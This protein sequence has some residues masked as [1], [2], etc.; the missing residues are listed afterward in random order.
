[1]TPAVAAAVSVAEEHGI[2][3]LDPVVLNDSFNLRVHLRPAP[4]V[5]RV[6]T[7]TALGRARPADALRR[8][9]DVV[10]YLHGQGVPVVP[11]SD[12]LPAGPHL[13]DGV[14][15]SFWKHVE[16]DPGHRM[17]PETAGRA[18]AGLHEALRGFPGELPYLGPVLDEP[19]RLLDL[20][21]LREVARDRNVDV[22]IGVV[23]TTPQA[24]YNYSVD[25]PADGSAPIYYAKWHFAPGAPFRHGD[26]LLFAGDHVGLAN[27]M[28]LNFPAPIRDYARA[29]ARLMAVP[30]ADE[31]GNGRQHSRMGLLRGVE[32]GLS[33]AW[34]AQWGTPMISDP[35]GRVLAER[36]TEGTRKPFV[37]AFADVPSGPGP[38]VYA[39]FGDW[40]AWLCLAMA[41]AGLVALRSVPRQPGRGV[42][43]QGAVLQDAAGQEEPARG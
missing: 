10:S 19:L 4:V 39:R 28:D 35:W 26:E 16:H 8:E 36:D 41:A 34:A 13:R 42:G 14:A 23:H 30:A 21:P 27:C 1:M 11:P 18:L 38:T 7:V 17:S 31:F 29:G 24:R 6:P 43:G 25:L 32:T 9:L 22:V 33:V 12:L 5:A 37:M 15:L 3:V 2:R 20:A 40:F